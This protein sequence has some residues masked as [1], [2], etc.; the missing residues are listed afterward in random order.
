VGNRQRHYAAYVQKGRSVKPIVLMQPYITPE[1]DG[2][3]LVLPLHMGMDLEDVERVCEV[4]KGG[5]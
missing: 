5:W 2:K 3:Y 1:I 4:I